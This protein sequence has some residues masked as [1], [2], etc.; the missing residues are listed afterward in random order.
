M[1]KSFAAVITLRRGR[2]FIWR[3]VGPYGDM[4]RHGRD[5]VKSRILAEEAARTSMATIPHP[6]YRLRCSTKIILKEKE[7]IAWMM[8]SHDFRMRSHYSS[9]RSHLISLLNV[10]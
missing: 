7:S 8:R 9:V 6:I 10:C 2:G 1:K 5:P 4:V 3:I